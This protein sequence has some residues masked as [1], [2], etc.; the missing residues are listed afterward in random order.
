MSLE[1]W[2][3]GLYVYGLIPK[4]EHALEFAYAKL[5]HEKL[6]D[7]PTV[8]VFE[9]NIVVHECEPLSNRDILE[10]MYQILSTEF[11]LDCGEATFKGV[12]DAVIGHPPR[13]YIQEEII[14]IRPDG[15]HWQ[16]GDKSGTVGELTTEH[17]TSPYHNRLLVDIENR[18]KK[19]KKWWH[20]FF[21][22]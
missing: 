8:D 19:K 4:K 17:K 1:N 10:R 11:N 6:I 21:K 20:R 2:K 16:C 15:I 7:Y 3:N 14:H 22:V 9:Q 5:K 12:Y 13:L 18:Q